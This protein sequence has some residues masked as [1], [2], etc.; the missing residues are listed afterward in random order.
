MKANTIS[1]ILEP[2]KDEVNQVS[3]KNL[4]EVTVKII[5]RISSSRINLESKSKM[6]IAFS[7]PRM[8]KNKLLFTFYNSLLAKEGMKVY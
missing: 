5:D 2:L 6:I 8:T 1:S 3:E 4:T 7:N